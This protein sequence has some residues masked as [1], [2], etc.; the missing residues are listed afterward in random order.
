MVSFFAREFVLRLVLLLLVSSGLL[1]WGITANR[2][3][4]ASSGW[5]SVAAT[6][7]SST[8]TECEQSAGRSG[9][10]RCFQTDLQYTYRVEDQTYT[11]WRLSYHG[12]PCK[13]GKRGRPGYLHQIMASAET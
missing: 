9:T 10:S 5:P 4:T 8:V 13:S 3:S 7:I 11:G 12:V 6:I 1:F 2:N